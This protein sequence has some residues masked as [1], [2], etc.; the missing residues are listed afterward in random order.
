MYPNIAVKQQM[1]NINSDEIRK[2]LILNKLLI[3]RLSEPLLNNH[4]QIFY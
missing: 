3:L 4:G 1:K 2:F